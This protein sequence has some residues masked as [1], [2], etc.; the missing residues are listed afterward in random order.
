[1]TR[2][3]PV[4]EWEK[5]HPWPRIGGLRNLI[6]KK[7]ENGFDKVVRKVGKRVLIDEDAFFKWVEEK[8]QESK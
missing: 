4:P 5:H 8:N 3:I 2:L 7:D 1:M 6:F